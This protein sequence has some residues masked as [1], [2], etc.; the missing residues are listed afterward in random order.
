MAV[1]ST[2]PRVHPTRRPARREGVGLLL[3][4]LV[5][6]AM[7]LIPGDGATGQTLT[8]GEIQ[9][10]ASV[11]G[12]GAPGSFRVEVNAVGGGGAT[13]AQV[14]RDGTFRA[15]GLTPGAYEVV[16]EALGYRPHRLLGVEVRA[17]SAVFLEVPLT[18]E[19]PPVVRVDTTLVSEGGV[20]LTAGYGRAL[21]G[22]VL[23]SLPHRLPDGSTLARLSSSA[24]DAMGVEGLPGATTGVGMEGLAFRPARH[25]RI[26]AGGELLPLP[27][28]GTG[29]VEIRG[30]G[31]SLE[32]P[33]L[34]GPVLL[35]G[36]RSGAAAVGGVD[37]YVGGSA[38]P[39]WSSGRF[40]GEVPGVTSFHGGGSAALQ[41]EGGSGLL[42]AVDGYRL[43]LP[44]PAAAPDPALGELPQERLGE[45]GVRETV[46][47]AALVRFD[48]SL[49]GGAGLTLQGSLAL[50]RPGDDPG[51]PLAPRYGEPVPV[52]ASDLIL[53]GNYQA[54]A[55]ERAV[56]EMRV[57]VSRS[58]RS[59]PAG[60]S[61]G[62][63][64][65][66]L[67]G[68]HLV[69]EG[70]FLGA[71][72]ELQGSVTRS[73][74]QGALAATF[75]EPGYTLRAGVDGALDNHE[76]DHLDGRGGEFIFPSTGA[77]LDRRGAFA[78]TTGG[79]GSPAFSTLRG[80]L[81]TELL[82][83]P[84]PGVTL[85]GGVRYDATLLPDS[86]DRVVDG[87]WFQ[88]TGAFPWTLPN[89]L[90]GL[91]VHGAVDWLSGGG[92][93]T[94]FRAEAAL[95]RG[96]VDPAVLGE[97]LVRDGSPLVRRRVGSLG[98]WPAFPDEGAA[99]VRGRALSLAG[100]DF[101]G[102][103]TL[104]AGVSA[105]RSLGGG[106]SLHLGGTF[107]RTENL[108]RRHDV[109]RLPDHAG[110]DPNGRPLYGTLHRDGGLVTALPGSN[111]RFLSHDQVWL[112]TGDG[113]S[114]YRGLTVGLE[115][116]GARGEWLVSYTRSATEDNL[117]GAASGHP[118]AAQDPGLTSGNG[119]DWTEATSDFDL[120]HRLVVDG[121]LHLPLGAGVEVGGVYRFS[122]GLPFTPGFRDGVDLNGDGSWGN[123]PAWIP[124]AGGEGPAGAWPCLREAGGGFA[125]RNGCRAPSVHTL[126][127]RLGVGLPAPAGWRASLTLEALGI[128]E[129]EAGVVD[130]ALFLVDEASGSGSPVLRWNPGFGEILRP[131]VPGRLLRIGVRVTP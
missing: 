118:G 95:T 48:A 3:P 35:L 125:P 74:V 88:L 90:Q 97:I 93:G 94:R 75:L 26:P 128:L 63:M 60:G 58:E 45:P 66:R 57:G 99:P 67:P 27:L 73:T 56:V 89:A 37:G 121:L 24:D 12:G 86:D 69:E 83:D 54:L 115:H 129:S 130:R 84:R 61:G 32:W 25:P 85:R 79:S 96:E 81:F 123:D 15:R 120:P 68:T 1:P 33:A 104:R 38:G 124:G 29:W 80:G 17:G 14:F 114:E 44:R 30:G 19:P 31:G 13:L 2:D 10:S 76:H 55:A 127:L 23:R 106:T 20:R 39:L 9:G 98:S 50:L 122:S 87:D 65:G 41:V 116:R 105:S 49:E 78:V 111:R 101:Q 102:P 109:N 6:A 34:S 103:G 108:L 22:P 16:V 51:G 112:F 100:A 70:A 52:E 117:L 21:T 36:A 126:D 8:R 92:G 7:A 107:R 91:G 64:P 18:E 4:L 59:V 82:W 53:L 5:G 28:S 131:W 71:G 113:W 77:W 40:P 43:Q 62:S 42:V 46:G 47:A 119:A 11:P 72:P 110:F